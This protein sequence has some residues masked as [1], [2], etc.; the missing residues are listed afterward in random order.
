MSRFKHALAAR[1]A[2]ITTLRLIISMML[3]VII[4]WLAGCAT[5]SDS[6]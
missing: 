1:D 4:V 6:L 5:P 2:H 3:L